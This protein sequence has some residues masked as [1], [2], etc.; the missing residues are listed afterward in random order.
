MA[1]APLGAVEE[2]SVVGSLLEGRRHQVVRGLPLSA[3]VCNLPH[4]LVDRRLLAVLAGP[5][6]LVDDDRCG[7]GA[8]GDVE[9]PLFHMLAPCPVTIPV[10]AVPMAAPH[11][12]C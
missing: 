12:R 9:P 8:D 10:Q 11:A 2:M 4:P 5:R 3:V 1:L 7:D 6:D